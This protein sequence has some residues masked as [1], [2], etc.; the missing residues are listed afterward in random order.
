MFVGSIFIFFFASSI[1]SI[2]RSHPLQTDGRNDNYLNPIVEEGFPD[3]YPSWNDHGSGGYDPMMI[4][5]PPSNDAP[6]IGDP[7]PGPVQRP[8]TWYDY[9]SQFLNRILRALVGEPESSGFE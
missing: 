6:N 1:I 4:N 7:R 5:D 3:G 2:A 8:F 9:F